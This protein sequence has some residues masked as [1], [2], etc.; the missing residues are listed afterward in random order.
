MPLRA[1][2]RRFKACLGIKLFATY[3]INFKR[4]PVARE[5]KKEAIRYRVKNRGKGD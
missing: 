4:I 3:Q 1:V 5:S 2:I